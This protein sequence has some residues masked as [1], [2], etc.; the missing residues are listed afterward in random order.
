M[1][2]A[3]LSVFVGVLGSGPHDAGSGKALPPNEVALQSILDAWKVQERRFAAVDIVWS[4]SPP[5]VWR[6]TDGSTSEGR[7][8]CRAEMRDQLIRYAPARVPVYSPMYATCRTGTTTDDAFEAA[9]K[10]RF[11]INHLPQAPPVLLE[12]YFGDGECFDRFAGSHSG[13]GRVVRNS[14]LRVLDGDLTSPVAAWFHPLLL[15]FRPAQFRLEVIGTK[16]SRLLVEAAQ[17]EGRDCVRL[18]E[19][20]E[21][22]DCDVELWLEPRRNFAIRRAFFRTREDLNEQVDLHYRDDDR[23]GQIPD[24]WLILSRSKRG[25]NA[26][27]FPGVDLLFETTVGQL[28]DLHVN[29][30]SDDL[31]PKP[32]LGPGTVLADRIAG[33][34][35]RIGADGS[36]QRI[37]ASELNKSRSTIGYGDVVSVLAVLFLTLY[38]L[39]RNR[40]S[41]WRSIRGSRL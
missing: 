33:G 24:S 18:V 29:E 15:A 14:S 10:S 37:S 13:P 34:T 32:V 3:I 28:S 40:T 39:V 41:I 1:F 5:S 38:L 11:R 23:A 4:Q 8:S 36:R 25:P 20:N 19:H 9:I 22:S 7:V 35:Y 26:Q 6:C 27:L 16:G 12:R 31:L 2:T 21:A 17:V 30:Q